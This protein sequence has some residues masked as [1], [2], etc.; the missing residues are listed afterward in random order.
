MVI[1]KVKDGMNLHVVLSTITFPKYYTTF[2]RS[3][4]T[5]FLFPLFYF[6]FGLELNVGW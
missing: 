4:T 2:I 6:P 1:G 3:T 5:T